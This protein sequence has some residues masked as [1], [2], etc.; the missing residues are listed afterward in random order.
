LNEGRN[1]LQVAKDAARELTQA[2]SKGLARGRALRL[3]QVGDARTEASARVLAKASRSWLRA[4]GVAAWGY[5]HAWRNVARDAWRGVAMLASVESAKDGVAAW[6]AGYAPARVVDEH[7]PDGRAFT[8]AG[9]KWIP[10]PEQTRGVPCV[11]C[12]LCW[13]EPSLW[14][15][16]S[17]VTFAAHGQ[18]KTKVRLQVVR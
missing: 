3:F 14:A 11:S 2:A 15:R 7:P 8:E 10:C 4:G 5:T 18:R 6:R 13:D 12:R 9:V 1:V 16:K 17:G